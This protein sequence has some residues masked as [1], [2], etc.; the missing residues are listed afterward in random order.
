MRFTT[1]RQKIGTQEEVARLLDIPTER[2]ASIERGKRP[3]KRELR[4]IASVFQITIEEAAKSC[5][6]KL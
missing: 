2:V 6:V 3:N 5:G 4:K 1:F